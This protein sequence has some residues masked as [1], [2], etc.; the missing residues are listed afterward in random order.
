MSYHGETVIHGYKLCIFWSRKYVYLRRT[1]VPGS[2][3]GQNGNVAWVQL[4]TEP[5]LSKGLYLCVLMSEAGTWDRTRIPESWHLLRVLTQMRER[6][7]R[8]KVCPILGGMRQGKNW[9]RALWGKLGV[10]SCL[11]TVWVAMS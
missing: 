4:Q 2:V 9:C 3:S 11:T 10:W 7:Q 5:Q 1:T 6:N 8:E